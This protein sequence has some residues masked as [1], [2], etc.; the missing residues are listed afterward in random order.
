L[1]F[2]P[3]GKNWR[4]EILF[5]IMD[6]ARHEDEKTAR[7]Y[8]K[9]ARITLEQ[10]LEMGKESSWYYLIYLGEWKEVL[11]PDI[12]VYVRN[13]DSSEGLKVITEAITL[14][15]PNYSYTIY[16]LARPGLKPH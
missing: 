15:T 4:D 7:L 6:S 14:I 13:N 16:T 10:M 12:G 5:I 3:F 1:L 8:A 2:G 11:V 9:G